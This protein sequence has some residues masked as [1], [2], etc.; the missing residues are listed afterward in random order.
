MRIAE[1]R[2]RGTGEV[3][4]VLLLLGVTIVQES[5]VFRTEV[6]LLGWHIKFLTGAVRFLRF[7]LLYCGDAGEGL[8]HFW[9]LFPWV[10][11][12]LYLMSPAPQMKRGW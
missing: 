11:K 9:W 3:V 6:Q 8:V 4:S 1:V 2:G 5:V 12:S 10:S 7:G